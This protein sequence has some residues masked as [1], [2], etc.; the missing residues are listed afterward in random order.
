M[1]EPGYGGTT[2]L[3]SIQERT[4]SSF[5]QTQQ[6]NGV[7]NGWRTRRSTKSYI[8]YS[9]RTTGTKT[10]EVISVGHGNRRITMLIAE[11][12]CRT[13]TFLETSLKQQLGEPTEQNTQ[14]PSGIIATQPSQSATEQTVQSTSAIAVTQAR[15]QLSL[16]RSS[17]E[18]KNGEYEF[19]FKYSSKC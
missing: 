16:A 8:C 17:T 12:I 6:Q 1:P 3:G 19:K 9:H 14:P 11:Q 15:K 4:Q 13:K 5:D 2:T 18:F 10:T 7:Y